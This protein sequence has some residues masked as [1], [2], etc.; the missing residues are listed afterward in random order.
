MTY[1]LQALKN[2]NL[3][4]WVMEIV[5]ELEWSGENRSLD[6]QIV[7]NI[8]LDALTNSSDTGD[9]LFPFLQP[10]QANF[11]KLFIN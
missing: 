8:F 3:Y 5:Q 6:V 11:L 1:V 7:C 2:R 4:P 10:F 9:I